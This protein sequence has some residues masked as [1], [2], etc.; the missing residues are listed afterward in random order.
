DIEG[1]RALL[2]S[3][4]GEEIYVIAK[5]EKAQAIENLEDILDV[6]DGVMVA[7][8]DLGVELPPEAVPIVQKRILATAARWGK[9]AI[10]AT[11]ML[12]SLRVSSR[13]RRAEA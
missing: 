1:L 9:F 8:G 6:S 13:P 2:K 11:Q 7:R 4:G 10:T 3:L 12:E 5:L